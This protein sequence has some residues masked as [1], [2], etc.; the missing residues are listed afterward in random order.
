MAKPA[1]DLVHVD[2]AVAAD[3]VDA[4]VEDVRAFLDLFAR[5]LHAGVEVGFEHRVAELAR[6]VRVGALADGEVGELLL[7][8]DVRVDRR[9]AGLE[10][11]RAQHGGAVVELLDDRAQV[12]GRRAA[13]ATDDV[14]AELGR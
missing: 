4:D 6:P 13:A 1:R 10:L 2:R 3:V 7:E 8:R 12:R 9:A 14:E 11:G 5:H